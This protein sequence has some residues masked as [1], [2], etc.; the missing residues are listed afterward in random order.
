MPP[1]ELRALLVLLALAIVGQCVRHLVTRP[2]E[3]PGQVQLL[4]TLPPGSPSAQ[5]DSAMRQGRP[6]AP[7]ERVDMDRA[8]AGELSRLPKIGPRLA[9]TIVADREEHGPF[10]N[11]TGLDR[12]AG[13]GPG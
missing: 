9:R 11:L 10:G 12:V 3:P 8:P 4:A 7:G 2:G 6:L 13:V 1:A 5:R